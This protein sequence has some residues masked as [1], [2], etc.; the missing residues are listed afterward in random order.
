M[1]PTARCLLSS[2]CAGTGIKPTKSP[3]KYFLWK[4]FVNGFLTAGNEGSKRE[5][6]R[7]STGRCYFHLSQ[8]VFDFGTPDHNFRVRTL[9]FTL[10]PADTERRKAQPV[11]KG[12]RERIQ[13]IIF[14]PWL[15]IIA[16]CSSHHWWGIGVKYL[17]GQYQSQDGDISCDQVCPPFLIIRLCSVCLQV[18][19]TWLKLSML[20]AGPS[21]NCLGVFAHTVDMHKIRS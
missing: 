7:P 1:S 13:G 11:V 19:H 17:H 21:E 10:L 12:L 5:G 8:A 2:C 18:D 6:L 20:C 3:P 16:L 15:S 14:S 9:E 4:L